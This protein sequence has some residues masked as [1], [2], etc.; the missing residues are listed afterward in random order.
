MKIWKGLLLLGILL[1]PLGCRTRPLEGPPTPQ[2]TAIPPAPTVASSPTVSPSPTNSPA[3][4]YALIRT[5]GRGAPAALAWSPDG[6][7]L[8]AATAAGLYLFAGL[9]LTDSLHLAPD[10]WLTALAWSPDG[11][12]L[13]AGTQDGDVLLWEAAT[14]ALRNRLRAD[15]SAITALAWNPD[16]TQ[17][18]IGRADSTLTFWAP[19]TG[20]VSDPQRA[21]TDRLTALAYCGTLPDSST[22]ALYT[23]GRDGAL[24]LWNPTAR[25]LVIGLRL[26]GS[27]VN[28]LTCSPADGRLYL[29]DRDG[30]LEVWG[31]H[32]QILRYAL[33]ETPLLTLSAPASLPWL[34]AGNAQGEIVLWDTSQGEPLRRIRAHEGEI[35]ALAYAPNGTAL[36]S[37]GDDGVLRLWNGAPQVNRDTETHL[38]IG[39]FTGRSQR[40]LWADGRLVSAHTD[41]VL[42]L[43]QPDTSP[44]PHALTGHRGAVTAL[45]LAGHTLIS[46]GM[47]GTLRLW[48]LPAGEPLGTRYAHRNRVTALAATGS[49]LVSADAGG[50][51]IFWQGEEAVSQVS[52]PDGVWARALHFQSPATLWVFASDDAA[53]AYTLP[54]LLPAAAQAA[55]PAG[56]RSITCAANGALCA[57]LD[58]RGTAWYGPPG[59]MQALALPEEIV[60][61]W[62]TPAGQEVLLG[63]ASGTVWLVRD[64]LA[65]SLGQAGAPLVWLAADDHRHR[66]YLGLRNG[67]IAVWQRP[68]G[69]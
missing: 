24:S 61:L 40:G 41:G 42:R 3:P 8:A 67:Q 68:D 53:R 57:A 12:N 30:D 27:A 14:G 44:F 35:L 38:E 2:G 9:P 21:H 58:R 65:V 59:E 31:P 69:G 43:W 26:P 15:S 55:W 4:A 46:G 6:T 62:L 64:G 52:L 29:A 36:A 18:A 32:G 47:D 7:Q 50:A 22:P 13:A 63:G 20:Q 56:V 37:L 54:S 28:A 10:A 23:A 33:L 1:T 45:A 60:G 5:L 51:L 11:L 16:G 19:L 49:G 66:I 39:A 48:N 34:A 25:Q 17:I